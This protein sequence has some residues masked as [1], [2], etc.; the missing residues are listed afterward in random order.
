MKHTLPVLA[1]G[2]F[3]ALLTADVGAA[4]IGGPML[5]A[6]PLPAGEWHARVKY[7]DPHYGPDGR[8]YTFTYYE[9]VAPTQ[10]GCEYQMQ[11]VLAGGNVS[12]VEYCHLV[13]FYG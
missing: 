10:S 9:I 6:D 2:L 5:P 12:V 4:R 8:Y 3:L 11:S 1:T 13:P 7:T